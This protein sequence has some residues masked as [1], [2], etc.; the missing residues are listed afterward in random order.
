MSEGKTPP[1]SATGKDVDP[2][3]FSAAAAGKAGDPEK[4]ALA[5]ERAT[6]RRS[7]DAAGTPS[8]A[9]PVKT[10]GR[11]LAFFALLVALGAAGLAGYLYYLLVV[12][13][14]MAPVA[15]RLRGIEETLTSQAEKTQNLAAEQQAAFQQFAREQQ[16]QIRATEERV[17]GAVNEMAIQAP[18]SS[19]E[20]KVAEV[21]YLLRI[22]NHRLLMERDTDGA[23]QLLHAADAI[24][25][26]LD[27]F[28]LFPVR[29]RLAD[30]ILAL[31]NVHSN[32]VQG[33]YL[34]LEAVKGELERLPLRIP[35]YLAAREQTER[36]S[37]EADAPMWQRFLDQ[38]STYLR[39]RRVEGEV[40][41]L[42]A[43][44]E[45]VY[46]ELNLRLMLERAQLAALRREQVIYQQ[47]LDSASQWLEEYLDPAEP[48][49]RRVLE[50]LD[51]MSQVDLNQSLPDISGSL[52]ALRKAAE[53]GA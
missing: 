2:A 48:R 22:A 11:L 36:T 12:S 30:E 46:L 47:S 21:A 39:I 7:A 10:R 40:K 18:P 25:L 42:L 27:D 4:D 35:A 44:D 43:P 29:A 45:A 41:P 26:E 33:L 6:K 20:W 50:E 38:I 52:E 53:G 51:E 49:V 9:A 14:P 31:E 34:R 8:A 23:L 32:D 37:A 16:A 15:A 17:A 1:E 19:R 28:G 3:R 5:R 13:A 24:L